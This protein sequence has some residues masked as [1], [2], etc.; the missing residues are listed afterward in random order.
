MLFRNVFLTGGTGF[1][2][3]HLI[4]ELAARGHRIRAVVRQQSANK[5]PKDAAAVIGDATRADSYLR[6]IGDC[7]TFVHLVGVA[8]PTPSKAAAFRIIDLESTR[9]AVNAAVRTG[10]RNFVYVSVAQPSPVMKAYVETR[11]QCE[12][13][14]THSGLKASILR[15]FYILGPGRRWPIFLKPFF[16]VAGVLPSFRASAERMSF[17][18]IKQMSG[19]LICAIENPPVQDVRIWSANEI[20]DAGERVARQ[21]TLT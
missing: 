10:I 17:V 9:Q 5:L 15:P 3:S 1:V 2:G 20:K 21:M 7:D 16:A 14:I 12:D 6:Q 19:A 13:I 11:K 18:T 8:H 4:P